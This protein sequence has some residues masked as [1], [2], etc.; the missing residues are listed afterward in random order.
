[1]DGSKKTNISRH[2]S[3]SA[4]YF[5]LHDLILSLGIIPFLKMRKL[6]HREDSVKTKE[7]LEDWENKDLT[8]ELILCSLFLY[9]AFKCIFKS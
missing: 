4:R 3:H 2:A 8:V 1:M 7:N 5:H 6:R 9:D